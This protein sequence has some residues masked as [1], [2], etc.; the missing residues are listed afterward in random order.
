MSPRAHLV[1]STLRGTLQSP[2][3]CTRDSD[4]HYNV[5]YSQILLFVEENDPK[6]MPSITFSSLKVSQ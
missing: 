3:Q 6:L 4:V 1:I 5:N 2:V